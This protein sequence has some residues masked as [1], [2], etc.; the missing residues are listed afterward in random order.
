LD[1]TN[2]V[3]IPP[4]VAVIETPEFVARTRKLMS[5]DDREELIGYLSRNPTAGVLVP[6]AGGVRKPRAVSQTS[7]GF[8]RPGPRFA[9]RT[10]K[11][12]GARV[13]YFFHS[14]DVPLFALAAFAKNDRANLTQEERNDYRRIVKL[15]VA[16]YRRQQ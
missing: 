1:Y 12:G 8:G 3:V 9:R 13:I 14:L 5:D 11:S 16:P 15:L 4:L 7:M 10:N 2:D 6:G